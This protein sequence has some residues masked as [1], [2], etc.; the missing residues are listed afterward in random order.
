MMPGNLFR[1]EIVSAF[2]GRRRTA[3][4]M[5]LII[6][7]GLPF[8]LVD[9][10][11]RAQSAGIVM[12]ILFTSF[13]GAAV[14]HTKL[15][16]DQ[17]FARLILLPMSRPVLWLDLVLASALARGLPTGAILVLYLLVHSCSVTVGAI[18][19]LLGLLCLTVGLLTLLGIGIGKL[20]RNNQE[21]HLFGALAV[22]I[23][24]CICG[25][26]PL[27]QRLAGVAAM[28][29]WNPVARLNVAL[30][31]VAN[32]SALR[33]SAELA[34]ATLVLIGV[35]ATA[36]VRWFTGGKGGTGKSTSEGKS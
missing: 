4:R 19:G 7:L 5:G 13:F 3:L 27:P 25:V 29:A 12:V 31:Q 8:V 15:L 30:T 2:A 36:I 16:T 10:P 9:M 14:G 1:L 11:A 34:L 20:A 35:I 17:R 33:N 22:V 6:L 32:G 26:T 23:L 21:V 28:V 18:T 24:A